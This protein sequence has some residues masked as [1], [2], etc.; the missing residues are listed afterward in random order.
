MKINFENLFEERIIQRGYNY[1]IEDSVHDV[2]RN[3]NCY[4]GVVYGTEI[5]DVEIRI[6]NNGN[7]E[8]ME[9]DCPYAEENNCKH[10]AALLYY[11]K[12]DGEVQSEKIIKNINSYNEIINKIPEFEIKNFMLNKLANDFNFQNEFRSYFVQYFEKTPKM[13]YEKRISQSIYEVMGRNGFLEYNETWKLSEA[14]YDYMKEA[15]NLIKHKEYQAPFWIAS[16][17]LE[18]IPDIQADDSGGNISCLGSEC[19]EIIENILGE[20][21]NQNIINEIFNW[22]IEMVKND[23]FEYYVDGI[24]DL[25]EEYFLEDVFVNKKLEMIDEKIQNLS[26]ESES[27]NEYKIENLLMSKISI[28][29]QL[30]KDEEALQ[31]IK[32]N[33]GYT[34]IRNMLIGIEKDAGNAKKVEKLLLDG[35]K[36]TWK[37]KLHGSTMDFVEK[38]LKLYEEE[39]QKEKYEVLLSEALFKYSRADFKYYK[40]L[41]DLYTKEQWKSKRDSVIEECE[42][43]GNG[44]NTEDLRKIYIEE[45]YYDKLYNSV[46][47]SPTYDILIKYETYLKKDFEKEL[48]KEYVKIADSKA[49][50]TGRANYEDIRTVLEHIKILKNGKEIVTKKVEEYKMKYSNRRLMLEELNKITK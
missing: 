41:K 47:K 17:I 42:K 1:Y 32:D 30:R 3:E 15:E 28:L 29:F 46:M 8:Y 18:K 26:Q 7:I 20:C 16:L 35:I 4:S 40:K 45:K 38:L 12:N 2:S 37:N 31:V 27:Y 22:V 43:A 36:L 19:V 14:M 23:T 49:Q 44:Y 9:C 34:R 5:Y 33:V 21:K 24:D 48:L 6:D 10:M 11:L 13:V 50:Y 39:N 25:L